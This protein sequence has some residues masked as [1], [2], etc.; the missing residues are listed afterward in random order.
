MHHPH[1]KEDS[2]AMY[3]YYNQNI[4]WNLFFQRETLL[5]QLETN[6]FEIQS[7]LAELD[8]HEESEEQNYELYVSIPN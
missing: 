4:L 2:S 1:A 8:I 7:T 5:K 3:R 6:S